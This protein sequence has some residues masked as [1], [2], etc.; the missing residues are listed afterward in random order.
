VGLFVEDINLLRLAELPFA[1]EQGRFS[2]TRRFLDTEQLER[3]LRAQEQRVRRTLEAFAQR[4]QVRW[5]FEVKRGV[6]APELLGAAGEDDLVVVGRSGTSPSHPHGLGSTARSVACGATCAVLLV[7]RRE[8]DRLPVF[9]LFDG[10]PLAR[11]ALV[12]AVRLVKER[13]GHL[14]VLLLATDEAGAR[15]LKAQAVDW[16]RGR[17]VAT[18]YLLACAP[19]AATLAQRM[20]REGCG[21]LVL[22]AQS[23]VLSEEQ[24]L[25]LLEE[26]ERPVLL[27]R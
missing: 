9:V 2:G 8:P 21:T 18:R 6:V 11:K 25:A 27:V 4:A 17:K 7:S 3:Q 20:H 12:I 14:T 26:L 1:M 15:G 10:S 22:P 16:L 13:G 5:S 24:V 23:V 19:D